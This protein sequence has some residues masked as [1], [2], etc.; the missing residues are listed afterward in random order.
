MLAPSTKDEIT[1][2]LKTNRDK[3]TQLG[4]QRLGLFGS[5]VREEQRTDSDI[6]LLVEFAPGC[7]TFGNLLDLYDF[8][9]ELFHRE[10]EIVSIILT[11]HASLSE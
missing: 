9:Q 1:S 10:I 2:L 7:E 8:L 4:V 6:D 5:F 11:H 3:L